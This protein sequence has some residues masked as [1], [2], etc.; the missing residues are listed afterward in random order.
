MAGATEAVTMLEGVAGAGLVKFGD[1]RSAET[2]MAVGRSFGGIPLQL[3]WHAGPFPD[4]AHDPT[5]SAPPAFPVVAAAAAV[6]AST[7]Q[8]PTPGYGLGHDIA[9]VADSVVGEE[10]EEEE[11]Y[12][13]VDEELRGELIGK[14]GTQNIS[15]GL[16]QG[17]EGGGGGGEQG[18][19]R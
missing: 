8:P 17:E 7:E 11:L 2:F 10:E 4:M 3:S 1:R 19:T 14:D 15:T 6:A 16:V 13:R 12:P 9:A 5:P 18:T